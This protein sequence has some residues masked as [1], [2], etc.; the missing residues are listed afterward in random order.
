[1]DEHSGATTGRQ[2]FRRTCAGL[3]LL[4]ALCSAP[5]IALA[6]PPDAVA[7]GYNGV[8]DTTLNVAAPGVLV[9]DTDPDLDTLTAVLDTDVSSGTLTLNADGSFSYVPYAS[10]HGADSFSY[11]ANDGTGSSNVVTVSISVAPVNEP[12]AFASAG[13]TAASEGTGYSYTMTASDGDGDSLTFAAPTL[14]A[15]LSFNGTNTIS[16]TPQQANVGT[17]NVVVT[18]TDNIAPTVQ[19]SFTITVSNVNDPPVFTN[20]GP[21][22]ASEGTAYSYTM[23]AS[24]DDG[25]PLTF[26]APTLP[27]WLSFNGTNTIS[28]TPQ[29]ADAPGPHNVTVTVSDSIAPAVQLS[30][31]I[32][33]SDVNN[34]PTVVAPIADQNGAEGTPFGPLNVAASF[35]DS[36]GDA[37]TFTAS[38]LTPGRGL[39]IS[40]GGV[41]SGTPTNAAAQASPFSVTVTATTSDGSVND[42]FTFTVADTAN[43]PTVV[44]PIPDQ[45]G[46]QDTPFGPVS[47]ATHF[48]DPDGDAITFSATGFPAGSGLS[49]NAAG[50]IT[51]TPT[52][53]AAQASPF[54]VTVT[55]TAGDGSVNDTFQFTV[56]NVN[57]AP[58][59]VADSYNTAEDVTL[60]VAAPGVLGNDTDPDSGTTPTA[61]LDTNVSSGTLTL[62]ANGSFTYIPNDDF[63]GTDSFTYHA[64]DGSLSSN[65]VTV[66]HHGYRRK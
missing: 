10:F 49:V 18:V 48:T 57:D 55:A 12:P 15:W 22:N 23:T 4:V 61:V 28:G 25:N 35:A 52:N 40:A 60:N 6:A 47:I 11:H 5:A 3:W 17:H 9:N 39:S 59:A 32:T 51:G 33:V 58:T 21:T 56:I 13:P 27:A 34:P 62:N 30:F 42:T 44:T 29:Q 54:N 8:E 50:T 66:T 38:G 2:Q 19:Q 1:M 64:S 7:D 24:D 45:S 31:A 53:A 63:D 41:I 43:S 65:V 16:G 14:P 26:A 20:A 36:D 46:T 37:L